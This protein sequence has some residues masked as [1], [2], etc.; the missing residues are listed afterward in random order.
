MIG[1]VHLLHHPT[2]SNTAI[3][4]V[5][6]M[7]ASSSVLRTKKDPANAIA[8]QLTGPLHSLFRGTTIMNCR[9]AM[10]LNDILEP[11]STAAD[12]SSWSCWVLLNASTLAAHSAKSAA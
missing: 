9:V 4:P 6:F 11:S 3:G 5:S 8:L 10:V 7:Y 2:S 12:E 1:G